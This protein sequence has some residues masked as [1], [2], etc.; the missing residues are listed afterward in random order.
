MLIISSHSREAVCPTKD[1]GANSLIT[2]PTTCTRA[3]THTLRQVTTLIF[4]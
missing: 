1:V 4:P 2:P 3:Q